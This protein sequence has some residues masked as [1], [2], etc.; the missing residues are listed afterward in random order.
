MKKLILFFLNYDLNI[1]VT[2]INHLSCDNP[3][4][5]NI[6]SDDQKQKQNATN[7]AQGLNF[8]L[9]T[10]EATMKPCQGQG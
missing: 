7:C 6:I 9:K 4:P 1:S 5:K 2:M 10:I 8:Y 3:D